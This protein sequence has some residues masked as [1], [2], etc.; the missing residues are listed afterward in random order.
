MNSRRTSFTNAKD[1]IIWLCVSLILIQTTTAAQGISKDDAQTRADSMIK[2]IK[3]WAC[4]KGN[5]VGTTR[6]SLHI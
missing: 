3:S 4:E 1:L 5:S 2:E 6:K